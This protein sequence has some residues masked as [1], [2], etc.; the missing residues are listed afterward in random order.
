MTRMKGPA[1]R[2]AVAEGDLRIAHVLPNILTV[3][4]LCAGATAIPFALAS[5]WKAAVTAIVLAAIFDTLDGRIARYFGTD[6]DFG[7]QLDSLA[8]LV[9]F[10]IAPAML[11]YLWMLHRAGGA[12]WA[13]ALIFCVCGAIRLARFMTQSLPEEGAEPEPFFVGVPTPAAACLILLPLIISFQFPGPVFANPVVSA[14]MVAI[15]S[16]LMVSRMPTP[17]LKAIHL[18]QGARGP[19]LGFAGL[20]LGFAIL[21]PWSTLTGCLVIYL[22]SLPFAARAHETD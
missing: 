21:W 12:G 18:P 3:L 15:C 17:S 11:V 9:S 13:M 4:G 22:A 16:L 2:E 8:D 10:G 19:A 7:A 14:T 1:V 20:L 6:T 5:N